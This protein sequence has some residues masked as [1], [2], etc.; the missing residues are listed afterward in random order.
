MPSAL[1]RALLLQLAASC[2]LAQPPS[3]PVPSPARPSPYWS[4]DVLPRAFHGANKTGM[5]DDAAVLLLSNYSIVVRWGARAMACDLPPPPASTRWILTPSRALDPVPRPR[6][7][8]APSTPSPPPPPPP[9][10]RARATQT[11][12]KWYTPCAQGPVQ[13]SPSCDVEDKMY[14]TFLQLKARAPAHT[15]MLYLNSMFNFA[16]YR[17]AGLVLAREAAGEKLLLRDERG[18]LVL[19]CN[20]GNHYC[21]VTTFDHSSA[22]MRALWLEAIANA[23]SVGGVDGVFADHGDVAIK[24]QGAGGDGAPQLCNGSGA[25]RL[26]YNFTQTFADAFNAGHFWVV[27]KSTDVAARLPGHGPVVDGPWATWFA[28]ACSFTKLRPIVEAGLSGAGPF[29]IEAHDG[30]GD[31]CSPDASCLANFLAAAEKHTYF[32]CMADAPAPPQPEFFYELGPPT[33]PPVI[34]NGVVRRS[35][36]GPSGLTNASVVLATG[37]GTMQWA[38]APPPP[39]PLPP[40]C[41]ALPPNT[42]VAQHDVA[43]HD[44]VPDAG[45]C[46]ALCTADAACALWCWHGELATR[47]CHLHSAEGV[48]HALPG[49]TSGVVNRT[50]AAARAA[51]ARGM[52]F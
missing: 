48:P 49:A 7:R 19:L 29:V 14:K 13:G 45:A 4:W 28:P 22:A 9:R 40:V 21:N 17:L 5:F 30:G 6:P 24:P 34:E 39:P 12:E 25:D 47:E 37:V 32:M 8:P 43:V 46:C 41:G 20:D 15:N 16:F 52:D 11:L 26:C 18:A 3:P 10:A 1:R 36:L 50:A 42:A 23:T 31:S 27:N 2:S 33:G 51:R 44:G 35:F 38:G